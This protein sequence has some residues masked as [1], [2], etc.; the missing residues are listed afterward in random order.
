MD[1][2]P[3]TSF[4]K[5][6]ISYCSQTHLVHIIAFDTWHGQINSIW[7][8]AKNGVS[9]RNRWNALGM[10]LQ[11]AQMFVFSGTDTP[12]RWSHSHVKRQPNDYGSCKEI[13]EVPGKKS[14]DVLQNQPGN[15][16]VIS[17]Q[18]CHNEPKTLPASFT[19]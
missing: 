2:P 11:L 6:I 3:C 13:F 14:H 19:K 7:S 12:I 1:T 9:F 8:G 17:L 16:A 10:A 4:L 18:L 5:C 15:G